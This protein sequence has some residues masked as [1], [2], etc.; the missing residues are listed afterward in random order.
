VVPFAARAGTALAAIP[1]GRT[2]TYHVT[3][4]SV[5]ENGPQSASHY[6]KFT[7]S[8]LTSFT[9]SV[10]GAPGETISLGGSGTLNVPPQL[11]SALGPFAMIGQLL[12][13][14]P[15]PLSVSASWAANLPVPVEGQTDNVP[16]VVTVTQAS[17]TQAS[18]VGNGSNSTSVRPGV[19]EFPTD[20]SVNTT[21]GLGPDFTIASA[22]SKI[23][24]VVHIG[25]LG[26]DKNYSSSW[27]I[28]PVSQ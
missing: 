1:I 22:T 2:M 11:K 5:T 20:V 13:G 16:M 24:I 6:V 28:T 8:A 23:S 21:I 12:R 9:V 25:R 10:D 27:T 14:A 17:H 15:Q 18:I 7:H 19:R 3:S 26:R 4:Q